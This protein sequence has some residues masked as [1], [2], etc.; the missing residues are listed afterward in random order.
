[1]SFEG[2]VFW[3]KLSDLPKMNLAG[4]ML[5]TLRVFLEKDLCEHY[6]FEKDGAWQDRLI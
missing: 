5:A 4:G 3:V 6:V 2:E 1:M